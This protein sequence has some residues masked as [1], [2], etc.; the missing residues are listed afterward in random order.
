M[1]RDL[2][3]AVAA[4]CITGAMVAFAVQWWRGRGK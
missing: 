4:L 2:V 3:F 1:E